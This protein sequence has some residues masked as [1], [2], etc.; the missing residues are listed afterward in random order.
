M[1]GCRT[2]PKTGTRTEDKDREQGQRTRTENKMDKSSDPKVASQAAR[3][4]EKFFSSEV[5][6]KCT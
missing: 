5:S 4:F 1:T 3:H 2:E 6:Q